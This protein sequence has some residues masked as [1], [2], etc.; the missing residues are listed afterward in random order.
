M[1]TLGDVGVPLLN[2]SE[3]VKP[4]I[5]FIVLDDLGC[6]DLHFSFTV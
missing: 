4:N 5:A 6:D 3:S 2:S 1:F